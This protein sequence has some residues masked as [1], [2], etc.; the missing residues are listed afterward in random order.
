MPGG[1][2]K[3]LVNTE[4]YKTAK[5]IFNYSLDQKDR[6]G[7]TWPVFGICQ[8][9][10]MLHLMVNQ[11]RAETLSKDVIY[12]ESRPIDW[13]VPRPQSSQLFRNFP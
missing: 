7:V 2:L 5:K 3:D 9:F 10:E 6:F 11:D 12:A 13:R 4:F 1:G 8:G